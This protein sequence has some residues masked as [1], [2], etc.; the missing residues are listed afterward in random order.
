MQKNAKNTK[1]AKKNASSSFSPTPLMESAENDWDVIG[2]PGTHHRPRPD[3]R[4]VAAAEQQVA[5]A[6]ALLKQPPGWKIQGGP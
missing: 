2:R 6:I 5:V 1:N 3:G 4:V